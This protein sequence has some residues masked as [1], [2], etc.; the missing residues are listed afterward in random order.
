MDEMKCLDK[1]GIGKFQALSDKEKAFYK[2]IPI[3][4]NKEQLLPYMNLDECAD[5]FKK[6][7]DT[8]HMQPHNTIDYS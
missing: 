4:A 2:P 6:T 1:E 7:I 3:E 5:N 8:K